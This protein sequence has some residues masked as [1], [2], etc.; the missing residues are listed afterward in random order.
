L[1][2]QPIIPP[3]LRKKPRRPVNSNVEAEEKLISSI[4]DEDFEDSTLRPV[5][6]G[7]RQPSEGFKRPLKP[8][9]PAC[10]RIFLQPR[11]VPLIRTL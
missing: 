2:A 10:R 1:E 7:D 5:H 4:F 9:A 8:L 6:T 3:D 11:H